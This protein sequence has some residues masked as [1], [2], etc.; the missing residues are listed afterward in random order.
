MSNQLLEQLEVKIDDIIE[1]VEILRLQVEE[2]ESKNEGLQAEN[3]SL[4]NRQ[5]HWEKG[6]SSLLNKL[7]D[8][9]PERAN[10]E[11]VEEVLYEEMA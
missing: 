9:Q 3:M 2:L 7:D 4:K 5:A 10:T 8:V 6:L 1:T 11:I